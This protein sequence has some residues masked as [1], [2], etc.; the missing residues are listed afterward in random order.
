MKSNCL[1]MIVCIALAIGLVCAPGCSCFVPKTQP[2]TIIPSDQRAEITIDG[3]HRGHGAMIVDLQRNKSH[4]IMARVADRVG[5]ASI[6]TQISRTGVLDLIG[7]ILFLL[8][9]LGVLSPGFWM[10]DSD[11]VV[12]ALPPDPEGGEIPPVIP[13]AA[14][15]EE[16]M[17][18]KEPSTWEPPWG[19]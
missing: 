19:G 18:R 3:T 6:G 14:E 15:K 9:F 7:G 2:V 10:L 4:S 1:R 12:L 8:P 5:V 16:K 17:E 11:Q 13:E